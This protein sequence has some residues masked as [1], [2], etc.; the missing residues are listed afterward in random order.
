MSHPQQPLGPP[1]QSANYPNQ[2]PYPPT[3][4]A[5]PY[6]YAPTSQ[7]GD[8]YRA[9][10]GLD[11]SH[12]L[13]SMRTLD[14]VPSQQHGIPPPPPAGPSAMGM[15]MGMSHHGMN[16]FYPSAL[17]MGGQ[18]L[19]TDLMRYPLP[20]HDPRFQMGR[21]PKK[22]DETHPT[23]NNCRK[24]KRECLGYDPIF[25][26]QQGQ[27]QRQQQQQQQQT[28][29]HSHQQSQQQGQ[30]GQQQPVSQPSQ[31]PQQTIATPQ[32]L[33]QAIPQP[34]HGQQ[35][36]QPQ[37]LSTPQLHQP[38]HHQA[39]HPQ[40]SQHGEQPLPPPQP[41]LHQSSPQPPTPQAQ[42]GINIS[43]HQNHTS[44]PS[45]PSGSTGNLPP[46]SSAITGGMKLETPSSAGISAPPSYAPQNHHPG[47]HRSTTNEERG[48]RLRHRN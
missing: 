11:P 36:Q 39:Q 37:P 27:Q 18:Y 6:G 20:P 24:S 21:G 47:L 9:S 23:C 4:A 14:A 35:L 38:Q 44:I 10:P 12:H 1:R 34:H 8:I 48:R 16:P 26:Q 17:A 33:P 7:P 28:H 32:T 13:P 19:H 15:G 41:H 25:K 40:P 29:Q 3:M 2:T 5:S 30:Q 31:Q 42:P 45:N 43:N 22:C 46:S